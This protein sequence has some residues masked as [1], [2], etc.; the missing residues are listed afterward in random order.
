MRT[1]KP[2][3]WLVDISNSFTKCA[4]LRAGRIGPVRRYPT[5][6]W[7]GAR[8]RAAWRSAGSPALVV[9]SSVVPAARASLARALPATHFLSAKSP[10]GIRLR[11]PAA[12][13][14]GADRLA[15]AIAASPL[16][17]PPLIVADLGT[18]ATFDVIDGSG[19]YVGGVIAPGRSAM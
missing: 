4:A 11:Y 19:A 8:W 6:D 18:A 15:N 12:G 16:Y 1:A 14:L 5:A 13:T 9:A 7:T 17:R 2:D 3:A 10:C